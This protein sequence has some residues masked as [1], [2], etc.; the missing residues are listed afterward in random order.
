MDPAVPPWPAGRHQRSMSDSWTSLYDNLSL[1]DGLDARGA[2]ATHHV[3]LPVV[4]A[5]QGLAAAL[6]GGSGTAGAAGVLGGAASAAAAAD[7]SGCPAGA[8]APSAL[9]ERGAGEPGGGGHQRRN[10]FAP[11][12]PSVVERE[13]GDAPPHGAAGGDSD[14]DGD[15]A[16]GADDD[17]DDRDELLSLDPKRIKRIIANRESAARSKERRVQYALELEAKADALKAAAAGLAADAAAA[18][19][20]AAAALRAK[21]DAEGRALALQQVLAH[22]G[23]ANTAL[24]AELFALQRAL[25]LPERLPPA[26]AG[27]AGGDAAAGEGGGAPQL[28]VKTRVYNGSLLGGAVLAK[29]HAKVSEKKPCGNHPSYPGE[30]CTPTYYPSDFG[31]IEGCIRFCGYIPG[32]NAAIYCN[33]MGG[34]GGSKAAA[35]SSVGECTLLAVN[36]S[37]APAAPAGDGGGFASAVILGPLLPAYCASLH[38]HAYEACASSR[39]PAGCADCTRRAAN[40]PI[41]KYSAAGDGKWKEVRGGAPLPGAIDTGLGCA[42]CFNESAAP[43][44]CAECLRAGPHNS[45]CWACRCV[46]LWPDI[47]ASITRP[48]NIDVCLTCTLKF[49]RMWAQACY[50]CAGAASVQHPACLGCIVKSAPTKCLWPTLFDG[51]DW[52]L[53]MSL[54]P[55]TAVVGGKTCEQLGPR[56]NTPPFLCAALPTPELVGKCIACASNAATDARNCWHC[57]AK[58]DSAGFKPTDVLQCLDCVLRA[59]RAKRPAAEGKCAYCI[60]E[61]GLVGE[62]NRPLLAECLDATD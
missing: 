51:Y 62:T 36:G 8:P 19:G 33:R 46:M 39:N 7:L 42:R 28:A 31:S 56:H 17:S 44:A 55:N 25:G 11:A 60:I 32:C 52:R 58:Q 37:V 38:R 61:G 26:A 43:R 50:D 5:G 6:P 2:Q 23:A 10:S 47:E 9:L 24:A 18:R 41:W 4:V 1:D 45:S 40:E 21:A 48:R 3:P 30:N 13:A 29:V 49:G 15:D 59:A 22:A 12:L 54:P 27:A 57:T 20:R 35:G 34:C 14:G 53:D 16:G